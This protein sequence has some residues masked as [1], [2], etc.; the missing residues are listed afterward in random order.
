MKYKEFYNN[1]NSVGDEIFYNKGRRKYAVNPNLI[2]HLMF[3]YKGYYL[4]PNEKAIN[5][6]NNYKVVNE[7][8]NKIVLIST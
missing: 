1:K 4:S 5:L 2:D 7:R 6:I 3:D 8:S